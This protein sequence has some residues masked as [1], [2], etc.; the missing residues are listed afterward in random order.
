VFK[1]Y[2]DL[3]LGGEDP[4]LK[5]EALN[6]NMRLTGDIL[7]G[8]SALTQVFRALPPVSVDH[9]QAAWQMG[10]VL[11]QAAKSEEGTGFPIKYLTTPL[12][13]LFQ[14]ANPVNLPDQGALDGMRLSGE[15]TTDT[16]RCLTEAQGNLSEP[17]LKALRSKQAKPD[18]FQVVDLMR[19][20]YFATTDDYDA[21]VRASGIL[22]TSVVKE[23]EALSAY[24]PGPTDLVRFMMR[25]SFDPAIVDLYQYD[26]DFNVKFYGGTLPNESSPAYR[27][28]RAQGMTEEQMRLYWY[29]HW[30]LP[31]NTQLYEMMHRLRPQRQAVLDWMRA[32][33]SGEDAEAVRRVGGRPSIVTQSDVRLAIEVNDMAPAW[34]Q[35]LIDISYHPINRTDAIDGYFAGVLSEDELTEAMLDNGYAPENAKLL[36]NIQRAKRGN[37]LATGSGLWT[38]RQIMH[39]YMD[40]SITAVSADK[41]LSDVVIDWQLR[42]DMLAQADAIVSANVRKSKIKRISRSYHVGL[43][44]DV[45]AIAAL[46]DAGVGFGRAQDLLSVWQND[47]LGRLREP[48]A[49]Q[50]LDW[51]KAGV[52]SLDE[53]ATRLLNLGYMTVDIQRMV[54]LVFKQQQD[55]S[56]KAV[57]QA[58]KDQAQAIS[59]A[60]KA[61]R[62]ETKDLEARQK[63]IIKYMK[64]Y[65]K[66]LKAI[67]K[68]LAARPPGNPVPPGGIPPESG[69][70]PGKP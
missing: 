53:L 30:N 49:K 5:E 3:V 32:T 55:S 28:A 26:K 44:D 35:S 39:A 18:A 43:T 2:S 57:D 20:G 46:T 17:H 67:D 62:Q 34:V 27:L 15:I 40:G 45:Q 7:G 33:N 37:R 12:N 68:E 4:R 61:R 16:W 63:A 19:R 1:T 41:L 11:A 25:D 9:K 13:Y 54:A 69:G 10:L 50:V 52:V 59:T 36:T 22:D 21:R 56:K 31:S 24:V 58:K 64:D 66:E 42:Q 60:A 38:Q 65:D 47:K 48:T 14:Y 51:A 29:S 23:Y 8:Y 70:L 6:A